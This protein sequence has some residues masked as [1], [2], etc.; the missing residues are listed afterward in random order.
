M[1]QKA[2]SVKQ[3]TTISYVEKITAFKI[4]YLRHLKA[5]FVFHN[6][7]NFADSTSSNGLHKD[8]LY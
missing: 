4:L 5:D 2:M 8:I 1:P 6:Q 7:Y 3:T